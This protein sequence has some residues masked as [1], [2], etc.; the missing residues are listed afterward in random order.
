MWLN[1]VLV[2]V[3]VSAAILLI[4]LRTLK[5]KRAALRRKSKKP[6]FHAVAITPGAHSCAAVSGFEN[7]RFLS[8]EAPQLP[9]SGCN[10]SQ[11]SCHY[12]HFADR[13]SEEGDRRA[14]YQNRD[15]FT[16]TEKRHGRGRRASDK[17][18]ILH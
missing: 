6:S 17:A 4:R 7:K 12:Q 10:C 9:V 18:L 8:A 14:L 5:Q 3:L 2:V 11:C 13:R 16:A 15:L 1:A